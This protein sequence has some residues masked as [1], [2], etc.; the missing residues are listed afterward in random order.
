[1]TKNRLSSAQQT[2][3]QILQTENKAMSAYA[4]LDRAKPFGFHAPMQIYRIL[5]KLIDHGLIV[6]IDALNMYL[7]HDCQHQQHIY[8]LLI[9]CTECQKVQC[10]DLPQLGP[11]IEQSIQPQHFNAKQ[12]HLELLGQCALCCSRHKDELNMKK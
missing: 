9:I 3:L 7:A 11:V 10:V 8:Q 4:L 2:L 5:N 6:K 1:M 12:Q